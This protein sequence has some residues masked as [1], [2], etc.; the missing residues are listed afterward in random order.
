MR[1][2][3]NYCPNALINRR[4]WWFSHDFKITS[5]KKNGPCRLRFSGVTGFLTLMKN[6]L[7]KHTLFSLFCF[8]FQDFRASVVP[9]SLVF[10]SYYSFCMIFRFIGS[11]QIKSN[12][13]PSDWGIKNLWPYQACVTSSSRFSH[14]FAAIITSTLLWML[15]ARY[16]ECGS[17]DLPI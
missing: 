8:A 1:C 4:E 9:P 14:H 10:F 15:S 3:W 11:Y 7:V 6:I 16:L 17:G 12:P 13:L 2:K 5:K